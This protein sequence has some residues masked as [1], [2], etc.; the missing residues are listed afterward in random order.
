MLYRYLQRDSVDDA[1][2]LGSGTGFEIGPLW[3]SGYRPRRLL[4]SDLNRST[5]EVAKFNLTAQHI[6]ESTPVCLFTSDLDA[7]PLKDIGIPIVVY[8][9]LHHTPDMHATIERM[10]H[11]G[12]R[13]VY[14]VEPCSNWLM[15]ILARFGLAEREEYS[16]LSPDRLD[17]AGRL[18][19]LC[20]Q[21][22]YHLDVHT[23]WE[24]PVDY[25]ERV[26]RG[27]KW[28][29]RLLIAMIDGVSVAT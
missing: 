4:V 7:V 28:V 27:R 5:L 13:V 2:F 19:G 6:D 10:L 11:Y 16:G 8:E 17:L 26:G 29:E 14:F 24:L 18:R 1:A 3:R 20:D 9:C 12:Y 23:M 22:G 21:Y 25:F 15:R